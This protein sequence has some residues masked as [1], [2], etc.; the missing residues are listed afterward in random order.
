MSAAA[1]RRTLFAGAGAVVLGGGITAGAAASVADL[2]P[3][4]PDAA[5]IAICDEIVAIE[6]ACFEIYDGP[7]AIVGDDAAKAASAPLNLRMDALLDEMEPLRAVTAAG[8]LARAR[9]LAAHNSDF[10]FSFDWPDSMAGRL[11][12][13]L[14]RDAAALGGRA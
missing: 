7:N 11:L 6:L 12:T 5:L 1:T 3:I 8:V 4:D 13:C 10:G 2:V 14:M 9:A